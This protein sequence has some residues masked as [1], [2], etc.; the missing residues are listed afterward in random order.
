[1]RVKRIQIERWRNFS[2]FDWSP[3]TGAPMICLVSENGGGKSS[4]LELIMLASDFA[5]PLSARSG[6]L[7]PTRFEQGE[8]A[9]VTL[10][11]QNNRKFNQFIRDFRPAI[12][13]T[14]DFTVEVQFD[15]LLTQPAGILGGVNEGHATQLFQWL[16]QRRTDLGRTAQE[17]L[18]FS[19]LLIGSD[20]Q[21]PIQIRVNDVTSDLPVTDVGRSIAM[22][23]AT[24]EADFQERSRN[25]LANLPGFADRGEVAEARPTR[26]PVIFHGIEGLLPD[27]MDPKIVNDFIDPSTSIDIVFQSPA[28]PVRLSDMSSGQRDIVFFLSFQMQ[29]SLDDQRLLLVDE[30]ELHLH[31][32]LVRRKLRKM[33]DSAGTTQVWIATHSWEAVESVGDENTFVLSRQL[34][35][36]VHD[37]IRRT[38]VPFLAAIA[39]TIGM[40]AFSLADRRF[41]FVEDS[42]PAGQYNRFDALFGERGVDKF[43]SVGGQKNMELKLNEV[44]AEIA[45][46]SMSQMRI[47]GLLDRDFKTETEVA[48]L[49]SKLPVHVLRCHELENTFLQPELLDRLAEI[50]HD[51]TLNPETL[52]LEVSDKLAGRWIVSRATAL[53]PDLRW[54]RV[55]TILNISL[56]WSGICLVEKQGLARAFNAIEPSHE[57]AMQFEQALEE[58]RAAYAIVRE[59][60]AILAKECFGKEVL[61]GI[62]MKFGDSSQEVFERRAIRQ[63]TSGNFAVP[64]PP[65]VLEVRTFL[66]KVAYWEPKGFQKKSKV[67]SEL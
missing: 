64:W 16:A 50:S 22:S 8:R 6:V 57:R 37:A 36:L 51:C 53:R 43:I 63:W 62:W 39:D 35:G 21:L 28:G 49:E 3:P 47:A 34:D 46:W 61:R 66:H 15:G 45:S 9:K 54:D 31:P 29:H 17:L 48:E 12:F 11:L 41:V 25:W 20:R 27:L 60:R 42:I 24:I 44:G 30:P 5:L 10:D 32:N 14:W 4:L 58:S 2:D 23:L 26:A 56:T 40:P 65:A 67:P 13:G 33:L 38:D 1:M 7:R 18:P 55:N 19:C 52:V 59:N